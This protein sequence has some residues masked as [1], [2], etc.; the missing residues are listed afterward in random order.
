MFS[1][2]YIFNYLIVD[3]LKFIDSFMIATSILLFIIAIKKIVIEKKNIVGLVLT[4]LGVICYQGTIPVFIA[5]AIFVTLLENKKINKEYFKRIL[6]CAISIFIAT[7]LSVAIV[8]LVPIITHMEMTD[9][10]TISNISENIEK[11]LMN[12]SRIIFNSFY[13]FPPYVWIGI[14]L[15]IVCISII[16]GIKE[17][18][19]EFSINVLF[20]AYIY[21][22]YK[23]RK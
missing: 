16:M 13:M 6:P 5:T 3:V 12:M 7:L 23:F 21:I 2:T 14:S 17:K 22:L 9:R 15:F 4:I 11:N 1:Y 20:I 18:K 10:I 8:K 19:I